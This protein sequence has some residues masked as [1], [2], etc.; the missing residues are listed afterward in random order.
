[1]RQSWLAFGLLLFL[2]NQPVQG[3]KS[4]EEQMLSLSPETRLEQRCNARAMGAVGREHSGFKPDEFV[5]YAFSDPIVHDHVIATQ[6][7]ALRSRGALYHV[8]YRCET[9]E[10]GLK[11]RSFDYTLGRTVPKQEWDKHYLVP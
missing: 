6:G 3:A 5:A 1:M 10:D 2:P 7:A 11:I 8:A 4:N 9:S